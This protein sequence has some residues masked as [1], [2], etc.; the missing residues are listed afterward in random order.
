[1]PFSVNRY[2]WLRW[3]EF[4]P[5][6]VPGRDILCTAV[7]HRP[8]QAHIRR[9]LL[10]SIKI[11]GKRHY[12]RC[13]Q[14]THNCICLPC[15]LKQ[16]EYFSRDLLILSLHPSELYLNRLCL[17]C[18]NFFNLQRIIRKFPKFNSLNFSCVHTFS[19]GAR[20]RSQRRYRRARFQDPR[21]KLL[22][23]IT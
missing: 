6:E 4:T 13:G 5:I 20:K 23:R 2:E 21:S 1:M 10:L 14:E 9:A 19:E 7:I 18:L 11:W 3:I 16:I 15:K 8:T 17:H 22:A 12:I